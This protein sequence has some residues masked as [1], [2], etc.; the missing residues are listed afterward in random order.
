MSNVNEKQMLEHV[1]LTQ[2]CIY[3]N[4]FHFLISFL[5][6]TE[7]IHPLGFSNICCDYVVQSISKPAEGSTPTLHLR[8]ESQFFSLVP[9][10]ALQDCY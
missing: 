3:F 8:K 9:S 5:L 1:P 4:K 2:R 6:N 10:T 7:N